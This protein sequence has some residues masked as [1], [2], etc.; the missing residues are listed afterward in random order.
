M[1]MYEYGC[2]SCNSRFDRLRRMDQDDAGVTCPICHSESIQRH[3]SVFASH[4]RGA[5]SGATAEVAAPAESTC[6]RNC[7]T[8]GCGTRN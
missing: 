7:S 4:S 3:L 2:L 1:P 5:T 6:S 8:C